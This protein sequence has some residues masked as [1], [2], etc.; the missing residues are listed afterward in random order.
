MKW[1]GIE[2]KRIPGF[3]DY[4]ASRGGKI[5]STKNAGMLVMK[6]IESHRH[7]LRFYVF[8]YRRKKMIKMW[9]HR[10]VLF[11]FCGPPAYGQECRH[12]N[13]IS[14]DNRLV[15]LKW[16]TRLENAQDC[17]RHGNRPC[18]ENNVSHKLTEAQ[19]KEM[20]CIYPCSSYYKLADKY[21]VS[22]TTI[23]TIILGKKWKHIGGERKQ[24]N[25]RHGEHNANAK[26]T[27]N[28]VRHILKNQSCMRQCDLARHH[29]VTP[30]VIWSIINR[31]TWKH[32]EI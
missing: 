25:K 9:V 3:P 24:G 13:G 29:S 20:R 27:D 5:L 26:L 8:F 19:V 22:H 6:Q 30:A 4:Y 14:S 28:N 1:K 23:K 31:R 18:G 7:G 12:L 16:G 2:W 17:I 32:V 21:G 11:A 15:N 10:A